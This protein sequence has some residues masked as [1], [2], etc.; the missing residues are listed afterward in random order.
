[1]PGTLQLQPLASRIEA[2]S[3]RDQAQLPERAKLADLSVSV[4]AFAAGIHELDG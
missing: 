2:A 3:L 1:M 4:S